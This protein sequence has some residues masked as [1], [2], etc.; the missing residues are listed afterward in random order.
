MMLFSLL[1]GHLCMPGMEE[2]IGEKNH[3][4]L[5]FGST[6]REGENFLKTLDGDRRL[7][8]GLSATSGAAAWGN[9]GATLLA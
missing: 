9:A 8:S 5:S 7:P 2:G 1:Q 6:Q 4:N 3:L